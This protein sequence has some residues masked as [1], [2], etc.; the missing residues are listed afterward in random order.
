MGLLLF[1]VW[2]RGK[3]LLLGL[4]LCSLVAAPVVVVE[5]LPSS[6][7]LTVQLRDPQAPDLVET[8]QVFAGGCVFAEAAPSPSGGA[9]FTLPSGT[10]TVTAT[11]GDLGREVGWETEQVVVPLRGAQT[12]Q[13]GAHLGEGTDLDA[14]RPPLPPQCATYT[15]PAP[16]AP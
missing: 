8:I 6:A 14:S 9:R 11:P 5:R 13:L 4:G 12:V 16:R 2:C 10:Y 1:T 15:T 3:A 7:T